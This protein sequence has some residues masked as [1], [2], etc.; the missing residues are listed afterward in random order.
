MSLL[1]KLP[2]LRGWA[3]Q[4]VS[5]SDWQRVAPFSS[6]QAQAA[7]NPFYAVPEG[8]QSSDLSDAA[9]N[10]ALSRR[11]DVTLRQD[12]RLTVK[13]ESKTLSDLLKVRNGGDR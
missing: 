6:A 10:I 9:C 13:G 7:D 3:Q 8:H 1:R 4:G 2:A 5:G 11:K 12:L